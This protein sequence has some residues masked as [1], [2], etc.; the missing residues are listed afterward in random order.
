MSNTPTNLCIA[1]SSHYN[2]EQKHNNKEWSKTMRNLTKLCINLLEYST[3]MKTINTTVKQNTEIH[4]LQFEEQLNKELLKFFYHNNLKIS[5]CFSCQLRAVFQL[6]RCSSLFH[7]LAACNINEG[8]FIRGYLLLLLVYVLH[9]QENKVLF[10]HSHAVMVK[11]CTKKT[12]CSCR[13][14]VL[15]VQP[16]T[17]LSSLSLP[18]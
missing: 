6:C 12:W 9:E 11:K 8:C 2:T 13:V 16:L 4:R 3:S 17:F 15:P 18:L 7:K 10:W 14:V 1:L 5:I